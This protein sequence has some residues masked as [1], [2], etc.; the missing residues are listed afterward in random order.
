MAEKDD[1]RAEALNE[2]E[3][4]DAEGGTVT[5]NPNMKTPPWEVSTDNGD[6]KKCCRTQEDALKYNSINNYP[7]VIR[8]PDSIEPTDTYNVKFI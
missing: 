5:F 7:K 1:K 3:V 6:V 2:T 4:G 8:Y